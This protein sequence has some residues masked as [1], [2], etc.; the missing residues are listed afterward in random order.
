MAGPVKGTFQDPS[1]AQ[2]TGQVELLLGCEC[3]VQGY[4]QADVV[5]SRGGGGPDV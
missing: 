5:R 3:Q 2:Q 4:M 1:P